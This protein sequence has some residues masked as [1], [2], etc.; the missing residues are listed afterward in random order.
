MQRRTFLSA[1]IAAPL[2]A[3][4]QRIRI[5]FLGANHPH[6]PA[7]VELVRQSASYDLAGVCEAEPAHRARTRR[8]GFHC[9]VAIRSWKIRAFRQWS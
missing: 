8:P 4:S 1:A 7:K 2:A 9:S 3:Q 5:A 6:G